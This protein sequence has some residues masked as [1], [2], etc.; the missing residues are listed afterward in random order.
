MGWF[1]GGGSKGSGGKS[2]K[3]S[4]K[5]SSRAVPGTSYKGARNV[6]KSSGSTR[7]GTRSKSVPK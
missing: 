3:G 4:G 6:N 1:G 7:S 5:G 2:G